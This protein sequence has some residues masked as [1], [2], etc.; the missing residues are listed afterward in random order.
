MVTP[1]AGWTGI[2][3]PVHGVAQLLRMGINLSREKNEVSEYRNSNS[4]EQ[5]TNYK[6]WELNVPQNTG[7]E[8]GSGTHGCKHKVV[9]QSHLSQLGAPSCSVA[10]HR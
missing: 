6:V 8:A 7:A 1:S 9:L 10:P 3:S 4:H 2:W 5:D